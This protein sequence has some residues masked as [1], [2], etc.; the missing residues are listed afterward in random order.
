MQKERQRTMK[1]KKLLGSLFFILAVL[2]TISI[3]PNFPML[4]EAVTR[5]SL[6]FTANLD[7]YQTGRA[8]GYLAFWATLFGLIVTLLIYGRRW[9][10]TEKAVK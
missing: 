7:A 2:L 8:S 5:F 10:K 6:I 9:I 3:I 4:L 1:T